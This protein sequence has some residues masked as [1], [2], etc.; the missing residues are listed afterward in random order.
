MPQF[1]TFSADPVLR[2]YDYAGG[3]SPAILERVAPIAATASGSVSWDNMLKTWVGG[4]SGTTPTD[5]IFRIRNIPAGDYDLYLY[6]SHGTYPVASV[7]YV[8]IGTNEPTMAQY[9]HPNGT[10]AV[11]SE[12]TNYVKYELTIPSTGYFT[13]RVLGYLS[14]LQ[15]QRV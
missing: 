10:V 15:L 7:F 11:F 12:G 8:G 6:A 5:S 14:G 9:N 1:S 3:L 13:F 2:L 4:Y